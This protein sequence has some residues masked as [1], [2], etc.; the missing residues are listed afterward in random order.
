MSI[1]SEKSGY[2][3][4]IIASFL[5]RHW[6]SPFIVS[7]GK[8]VNAALLPRIVAR[9]S[10]G[11]L[12][13]LATYAVDREHASCELVSIDAIHP[14]K[15]TGSLLLRA[16][17]GEARKAGCA[18]LWLITLND[19]PEAVAFYVKRG[20]CLVGVHRNAVEHS[21]LLKPEIPKT[22]NHGIPLLDEWE[23]EK[24]LI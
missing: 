11:N 1:T 3:N 24:K 15:G 10:R 20:F 14:N 22:G 13:G 19:N 16:V 4:P 6:G 12:I 9:D 17:E 8:K 7:K 23:F 5:T 18:R 2:E 21:R